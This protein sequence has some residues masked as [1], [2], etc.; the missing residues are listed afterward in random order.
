M[1]EGL[2]IGLV[3]DEAKDS[4]GPGDYLIRAVLGADRSTKA[5]AVGVEVDVGTTVGLQVRDAASADADLHDTLASVDADAAAALVFTCTSR[6]STFFGTP[7]HDASVVSD[8]LDGGPTAG[9]FSAGEIGPVG[10]RSH[11]HSFSTAILLF[12]D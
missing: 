10:P 11:L 2:H 5:V 3:V 4:F 8:H 9:M 1:A 12:T 7:D 6:G